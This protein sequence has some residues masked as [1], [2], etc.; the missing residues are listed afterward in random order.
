MQWIDEMFANMEKDRAAAAAK[1]I[2]KA[3]K[4]G[5]AHV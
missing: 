4:I 1:R 5:R 3:D 2:E